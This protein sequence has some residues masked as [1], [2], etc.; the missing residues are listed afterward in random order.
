MPRPELRT[1]VSAMMSTAPSAVSKM[2]PVPLLSLSAVSV[3]VLPAALMRPTTMSPVELRLN[4]LLVI[5]V[6]SRYALPTPSRSPKPG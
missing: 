6:P 2:P 3:T 5:I 4:A 1:S